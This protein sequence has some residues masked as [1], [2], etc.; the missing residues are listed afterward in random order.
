[1]ITCIENLPQI[2]ISKE[3]SLSF[4]IEKISTIICTYI[5]NLFAHISSKSEGIKEGS[6][7]NDPY[8]ILS[9]ENQSIDL[10]FNY[11]ILR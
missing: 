4:I 9:N 7:S 6:N 8:I 3:E 10:E 11:E 1:M 5:Y 2:F